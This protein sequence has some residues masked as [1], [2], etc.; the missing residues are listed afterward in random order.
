MI[1]CIKCGTHNSDDAKW[2][3][4]CEAFLEWD[5]EKVAAPAPVA[6]VPADAP[7]PRRGL[8]KR[9]KAAVGI[10]PKPEGD[11]GGAR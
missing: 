2:C 5:G 3:S 8:I 11:G 7:P 6:E 1:V 10:E 4:G 9:I